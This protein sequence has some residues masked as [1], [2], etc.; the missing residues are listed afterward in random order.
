MPLYKYISI[1]FILSIIT[2]SQSHPS[3]HSN[4]TKESEQIRFSIPHGFYESSFNLEIT[5]SLQDAV[6]LY[7]LDCSDPRYSVNTI[8]R[9]NP[10]QIIIDPESTE[11]NKIAS[12]VVIVRACAVSNQHDTGNTVTN[13]YIF[14]NKISSLSPDTDVRS[15]FL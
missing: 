14:V 2:Y 1:S 3:G 7:T 5:S 8:E 15:I 9:N 6:I 11:N 13:S 4:V 10:A 12:P